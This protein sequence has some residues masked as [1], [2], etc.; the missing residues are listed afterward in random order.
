MAKKKNP[1]YVVTKKGN[2]VEEA[3]S[4]LD[5]VI[6]KLNLTPIIDFINQMIQMILGMVKDYPTFLAAKK[7]IDLLI[8]RLELFVKFAVV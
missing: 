8:G 6:K 1:L 7:F 4:L 5:V 3:S 2:V